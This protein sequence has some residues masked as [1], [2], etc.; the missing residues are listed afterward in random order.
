MRRLRLGTFAGATIAG[1]ALAA[2]APSCASPTQIVV[3]VQA[4]S[5]LCA[6]MTTGIAVTT[7]DN[8]ENEPLEIYQEG[9]ATGQ[10]VGTLTITPSGAKDEW[11]GIRI[12][13][14][15][16]DDPDPDRCGRTDASGE[17]N[18]EDCILAR[19]SIRFVPGETVRLTVRLTEDCVGQY[20]GA[21]K[22]CNLGQCVKPDDL[23]PDGGNVDP[24]DPPGR[25][26]APDAD[27]PIDAAADAC[28]YCLGECNPEANRCVVDCEGEGC[29]KRVCGAGLDCVIRCRTTNACVFT[30][31]DT[32][33]SCSFECTGAGQ[34]HCQD[35]ACRASSCNVRCSGGDRTCLGVTMDGGTNSL[36]CGVVS[37]GPTCV[38]TTCFGTCARDCDGGLGCAVD[39]ESRCVGDCT[40]W[41]DAGDGGR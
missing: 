11:V 17:A 34:R 24:P 12:I 28:T 40:N 23:Q 30:K 22:E 36:S 21:D 27:E 37:D 39:D 4:T 33:G 10:Q 38:D 35:I 19:R 41:E 9:C 26:G 20:C 16:G 3:D 7:R 31:C 13:A 29:S 6:A 18:W 1:L 25:D 2:S 5:E 15:V 32:T 14:S 8:I